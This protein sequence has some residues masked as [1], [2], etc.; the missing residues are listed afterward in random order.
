MSII[1]GLQ[2]SAPGHRLIEDVRGTERT[3]EFLPDQRMPATSRTGRRNASRPDRRLG[4]TMPGWKQ[5][6]IAA[7]MERVLAYPA[8]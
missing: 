5:L 7:W 2:M 1:G 8:A 4:H 6:S 3:A